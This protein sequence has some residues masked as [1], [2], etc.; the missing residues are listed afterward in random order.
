MKLWFVRRQGKMDRIRDLI[1]IY[2]KQKARVRC[3]ISDTD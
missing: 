1:L 2:Y 3:V